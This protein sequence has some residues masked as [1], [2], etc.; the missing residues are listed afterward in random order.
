MKWYLT[1]TVV[2]VCLDHLTAGDDVP[3]SEFIIHVL[4]THLVTLHCS[5]DYFTLYVN[6]I[7]SYHTLCCVLCLK[8]F[9]CREEAVWQ[10]RQRT[11][12]T[13]SATNHLCSLSAGSEVS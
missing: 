1:G 8:G 6:Y 2:L 5:D 10:W 7:S 13:H 12:Q 11:H 9:E 4:V 3:L